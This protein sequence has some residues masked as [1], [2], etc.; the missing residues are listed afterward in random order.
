MERKT[1]TAKCTRNG[2]A[3]GKNRNHQHFCPHDI[4]RAVCSSCAKA[5]ELDDVCKEARRMG[6]SCLCLRQQLHWMR[7]MH[8]GLP[9]GQH[10]FG[11]QEAF[12]GKKLHNMLRL[13]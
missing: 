6:F 1:G 2:T 12:M 13:P 9:H 7:H 10:H 4:K 8:K 3:T 5:C 11:G